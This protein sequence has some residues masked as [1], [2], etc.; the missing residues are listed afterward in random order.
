MTLATFRGRPPA[1]RCTRCGH[2]FCAR[3]KSG[4]DGP[5]Y[6][7]QCVHL[8]VLGDGL[9]PETKSM[10][11]YQVERYDTRSRRGR[12]IASAVLPGASHLL[13]GRAWFGCG[14]LM[15]WL[16]A[17]IGGFPQ[18]LAPVERLLGIGIHLAGLRPASIPDVYGL[19]AVLLLALPLGIAVWLAGNVGFSRMRRV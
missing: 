9:A 16:L 3:C 18:G 4:R 14:L 19:D 5:E 10:K 6:C 2:P 13:A 7:S 12:R 1:Q 11:L 17:W 15:L 8:F